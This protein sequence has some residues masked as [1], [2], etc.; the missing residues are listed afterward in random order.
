MTTIIGLA[1]SLRR[2]SLNSA[3]LRATAALAPADLALKIV[4]LA[5]FPI[6]NEDE[7]EREGLPPAA[8]E[9]KELI[10]AADGILVASPEY[11]NSIPGML[12]NAVDWLSVPVQDIGRVFGGK[13][14]ALMGVSSGPGGTAMS[15]AAWLPIIRALTLVPWFG[16]RSPQIGRGHSVID[17]QGNITDPVLEQQLRSFITG[18]GAFTRATGSRPAP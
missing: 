10:A 13:T 4:S 17:N 3:M 12:K 8:V 7:R 11:N 16:M 6:Y 9:L 5:E 14:I 18:F 1:G 2:A 15:Q